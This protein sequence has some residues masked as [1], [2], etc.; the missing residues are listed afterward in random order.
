MGHAGRDIQGGG[1]SLRVGRAL[2]RPR[3]LKRKRC[4]KDEHETAEWKIERLTPMNSKTAAPTM[5]L[6]NALHAVKQ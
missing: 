6:L 5:S 3:F 1:P 2:R 4:F